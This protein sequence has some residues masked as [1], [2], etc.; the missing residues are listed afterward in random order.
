MGE[1]SGLEATQGHWT[2]ADHGFQQA[3]ALV[4]GGIWAR[5]W[6]KSRINPK[7]SAGVRSCLI[8]YHQRLRQDQS[9][10]EKGY[11]GAFVGCKRAEKQDLA[12][13]EWYLIYELLFVKSYTYI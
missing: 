4:G 10:T 11:Y 12:L 5:A 7:L 3:C 13:W 1:T 6:S 8:L 9:G 2:V